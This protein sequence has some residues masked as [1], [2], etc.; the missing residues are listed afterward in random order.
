MH[1]RECFANCNEK[2]MSD[3]QFI[4]TCKLGLESTV[5]IQLKKLGIEPTETLDARVCF[6]GNFGTM[7]RALLWLR[8]AE[9]LHTDNPDS[10]QR[11]EREKH[12]VLRFGLPKYRKK[13]DCRESESVLSC[14]PHSGD[15]RRS[16]R[17]SWY[18]AGYGYAVAGLLRSR[19]F[20]TRLSYV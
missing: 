12:L 16:D 9:R 4:A 10:C 11:E 3:M 8:T 14:G 5:A 19:A 15:R 18:F 6:A 20:Q 13:S 17:G 2:R 1:C 7:A